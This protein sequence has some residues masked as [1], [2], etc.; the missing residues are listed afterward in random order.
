MS[1]NEDHR[2]RWRLAHA[3]TPVFQLFP[4]V[5]VQGNIFVHEFDPVVLENFPNKLTSLKCCPD[6]TEAGGVDDNP[7]EFHSHIRLNKAERKDRSSVGA[8]VSRLLSPFQLY[9]LLLEVQ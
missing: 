4:I 2:E 8:L 6:N 5:T 3:L 7:P 9:V 1:I